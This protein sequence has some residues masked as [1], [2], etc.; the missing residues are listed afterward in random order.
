MRNVG[1]ITSQWT[2]V[3]VKCVFLVTLLYCGHYLES[4]SVMKTCTRMRNV[5]Q[6]MSQCIT[7][8]IKCLFLVFKLLLFGH[9][10]KG[11]R[12]S[13]PCAPLFEGV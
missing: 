11:K 4:T 13:C 1:Q 7:V 12:C 6:M 9:K 5:G 8:S 2:N 3:S 10:G